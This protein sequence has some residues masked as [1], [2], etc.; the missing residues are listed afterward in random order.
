MSARKSFGKLFLCGLFFWG[1][2]DMRLPLPFVDTDNGDENEFT[3]TAKVRDFKEGNASDN[4]GTHP[5]FNQSR[6]TCDPSMGITVRNDLDTSGAAD[7][8]FPGDNRSPVLVPELSALQLRCFDPPDRFADWFQDKE[9]DINRTYLLNLQFV[10]DGSG[11]FTFRD[12]RFF[13]LDNGG[14]Y[15]K[16]SAGG[17]DP[18]GN[19]Q[20]GSKDEVDLTQHN[21]GFTMEFHGRF[22]HQAGKGHV[23]KLEGDDDLWVFINGIRVLDL[24][25]THPA[26]QGSIEMDALGLSDG[27]IYP[28][29]FY[30]AERSVASSK[31]TIS[32]PVRISPMK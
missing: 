13:P 24:G 14:T 2:G 18:F 10:K 3:L 31:L 6:W 1:C 5:H 12:I 15:K 21:Y 17:P 9:P 27:A 32:T 28:I 29:D 16:A 4:A 25:G 19:L 26:Q 23:I 30:F 8:A 22:K 20:V 11:L 7:A